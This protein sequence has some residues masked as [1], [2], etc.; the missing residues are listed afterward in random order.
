[1]SS[2]R[3]L[4]GAGHEVLRIGVRAILEDNPDWKVVA[5]ANDG[6]QAIEKAIEFRPDIAILDFTIPGTNGLEAAREIAKIPAGNKGADAYD[7]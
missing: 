2:V 1:M 3:L 7:L 6:Q 5:E 4:V